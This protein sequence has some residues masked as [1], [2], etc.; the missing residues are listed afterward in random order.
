MQVRSAGTSERAAN[1]VTEGDL[2]WA[3]RVVVFE[4]EHEQWIRARFAGDLPEIIDVGV[5][6][7]F[8]AADPALRAELIHSS[9]QTITPFPHTRFPT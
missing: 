4:A 9:A 1:Q 5:P 3:D 8:A 6:D 7:D 2:A